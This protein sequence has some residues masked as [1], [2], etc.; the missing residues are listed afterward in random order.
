MVNTPQLNGI[1][2]VTTKSQIRDFVM[3]PYEHYKN[4]P[5]WV[6]PLIMDE[7]KLVD[8]QANPFYADA[9]LAMFIAEKNGKIAG[10]IG[11]IDNR[12]YN[13]YHKENV[14]FFGFFECIDDQSVANLLFK[15]ASDWLKTKGRTKMIGPFNPS[16][17]DTVGILLDK[18][19]DYPS[20]MMPYT[21]SYYPKLIENAGLSK[22]MDVFAYFVDKETVNFERIQRAEEVIRQRIPNLKIRNVN[23]SDFKNEVEIIKNVFNKAWANNWGFH[24]ISDAI[25]A[26]LGKDLK[27]VIDTDFAH[28]AE[29]DGHAVA[30]SIALPNYNQALRMINGKLLPF[31]LFKLLYYK[32]KINQL[33]IALMGVIPEYQGRGIDAMMHKEAIVN[34]I[35][36]GYQ[37][38]EMSWVLETNTSMLRLAERMGAVVDKTY[39]IYGKTIA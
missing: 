11:A 29:I 15:V 2:L 26:K 1:H 34:G 21:K 27:P 32:R 12:I 30:F 36:K 6:A 28:V 4:D 19:D 5:Y 10:R 13:E 9:E 22:E 33:R 35:R 39:R 14:G 24:P 23:L 16:N 3:F 20:I 37:S 25:F 17:M 31:G 7:K 38:A 8:S 18:F